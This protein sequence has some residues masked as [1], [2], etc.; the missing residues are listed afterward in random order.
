VKEQRAQEVL[1][2]WFGPNPLAPANLPSRL[3]LWFG[4][5]DDP[6]VIAE[7]DMA[8]TSRFG[9]LIE[10]AA[11]GELDRWSGSPH[12]LLALILLL[13]QFPRHAYRG[14]ALAYSR[15]RKAMMLVLDGMQTGADAALTPIQRLFF[16]LPLQHAESLEMQEE[17]MAA[18]RRLVADAP[19]ANR[20]FFENVLRFAEEHRQVISRFGRF[21][22]RNGPL[23]RRS[24]PEEE[25]Y[26]ASGAGF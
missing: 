3:H 9:S 15:D 12:R 10:A 22:H 18:Y 25:H 21:P 11:V 5:E 24:T 26:L 2:F 1:D 4:N 20:Q 7:R 6:E 23:S 13:D 8:I 19:E 17:S 14:R 16:Y